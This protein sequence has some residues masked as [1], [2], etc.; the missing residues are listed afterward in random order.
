MRAGLSS[1]IFLFAC[2]SYACAGAKAPEPSL[3]LMDRTTAGA[4]RCVVTKSHTRP[5]VIEWDATDLSMFEAKA[6]HDT[7]FVRYEGCHLT[8]LDCSDASLRGKLGAY[9]PPEW[10]SGGVEGFDMSTEQELYAQLPLGAAS[11]SGRLDAGEALRLRY[12]V[13]GVSIATRDAIHRGELPARCTSATHFVEAYNLGAFELASRSRTQ[14]GMSA[15]VGG[16]GAGARDGKDLAVLKR[17]GELDACRDEASRA[18]KRC[19]VPIRI[20][21][22]AIDDGDAP[23]APAPRP[24]GGDKMTALLE[25]G[26]I[27]N[28]AMRKLQ[29]GDGAGCL[30]DLERAAEIDPDPEHVEI[31]AQLHGQCTMKAGKCDAGKEL[32]RAYYRR[33]WGKASTPDAVEA[34]VK[35]QAQAHC[36]R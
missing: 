12:F 33:L 31:V 10:T 16:F 22:R 17:G 26:G 21:L 18:T 24:S 34:T 6:A 20:T 1:T 35:S 30:R 13:S 32:L 2:A 3:T 9:R 23:P 29:D 27:R 36:P 4:N 8:V 5:F 15:S 19:Q 28:A 11:L 14:A 7:V 25:A